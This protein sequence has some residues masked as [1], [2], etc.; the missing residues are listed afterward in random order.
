MLFFLISNPGEQ[1]RA[2]WS[3]ESPGSLRYGVNNLLDLIHFQNI[4]RDFY[5]LCSYTVKDS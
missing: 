3:I 4:C 1:P 2:E 5:S